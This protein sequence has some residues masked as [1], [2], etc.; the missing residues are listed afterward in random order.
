[1]IPKPRKIK[2][3]LLLLLLSLSLFVSTTQAKQILIY[4]DSLSAAYGMDLEKGW[5]HLLSESL[6]NQHTVLNASI[7]GETSSGGLA[8][9]PITIAELKPD[10]LLLELGAN[11]GLQGL[12]I[13][14]MRSNLKERFLSRR[15]CFATRQYSSRWLTP[16]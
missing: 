2:F 6:K 3:T 10:L 5:A 13:S 8:R 4:G 12:S 9:M 1:M 15:L 11:D 14:N 16:Y 7:S